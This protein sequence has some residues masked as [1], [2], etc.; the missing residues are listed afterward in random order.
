VLEAPRKTGRAAAAAICFLTRVPLGGRVVLGPED[1]GRGAAF[2]PLVGAGIGALAGVVATTLDGHLSPVLAAV[3]A[4]A[5]ETLVTGA[6]HLDALADTADGLGARTRERA[7]AVMREPTIGA[8]GATALALDLLVKTAAIAAIA[9]GP[10]A[11]PVLA[12]AFGLSRAAPV[13][14]AWA[15]PYAR[16]A[17][18]TGLALTNAAAGWPAAG[19]AVALAGTI[20]ALGVRGVWLA[21]AALAA[22]ALVGLV[23]RRRLGGVTG[24]VLGAGVELTVLFTLI[25]AAAS[26]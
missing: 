2:F 25:A 17:G 22:V 21:A 24:D 9:G 13:A 18:G 20:A 12:A 8:F 5:V 10:D 6:I 15:L 19:I 16:A 1:V 4:V 3:L 26:R 11:I 7:L 23:A 14:L